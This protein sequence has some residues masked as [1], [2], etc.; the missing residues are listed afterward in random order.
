MIKPNFN[1]CLSRL[2]DDHSTKFGQ[3]EPC[4]S[5]YVRKSGHFSQILLIEALTQL[6]ARVPSTSF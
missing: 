2:P 1:L 4:E 5:L 3:I 6:D